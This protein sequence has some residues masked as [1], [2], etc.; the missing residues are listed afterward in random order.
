LEKLPKFLSIT[1]ADQTVVS[2]LS[3]VVNPA[4]EAESALAAEEKEHSELKERL[5]QIIDESAN[6]GAEVHFHI[7]SPVQNQF[8]CSENIPRA[9]VVGSDGSLSPCVMKQIPKQGE[10]YYYSMGR[11]H[12]YQNLSFGNIRKASLNKIW[13]HQEYQQFVCDVKKGKAPN[14]CRNCL[15]G[16]IDNLG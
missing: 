6:N 7:V 11:K 13:Y 3:F 12:L 9:V 10:N 15:K 1:G 4:M 2:S 14:I 8:S 5:T 16:N